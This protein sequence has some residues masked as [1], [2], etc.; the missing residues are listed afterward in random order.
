MRPRCFLTTVDRL[1]TI[2]EQQE[3]DAEDGDPDCFHT[4]EEYVDS[5]KVL[6]QP[7][8]FPLHG[9]LRGHRRWTA[10]HGAKPSTLAMFL[11]SHRS[12]AP[13]VTVDPS[14]VSLTFVDQSECA[15]PV[16]VRQNLLDL[17]VSHSFFTG[18]V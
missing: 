12:P 3:S 10:R 4:M 8:G 9:P 18:L 1:P 11:S 2:S 17:L 15:T 5:I 13:C 16:R 14:E 7:A 6:S